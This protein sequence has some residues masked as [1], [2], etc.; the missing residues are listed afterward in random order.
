[1]T[2]DIS[3]LGILSWLKM[4]SKV[5]HKAINRNYIGKNFILAY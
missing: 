4:S 2:L 5:Y 3:A 1:M